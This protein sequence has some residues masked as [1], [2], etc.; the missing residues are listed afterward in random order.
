MQ[1]TIIPDPCFAGIPHIRSLRCSPAQ[2]CA[3][4]PMLKQGAHSIHDA[5][6]PARVP[7]SSNSS[8]TSQH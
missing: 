7:V 5:I 1:E 3:A 8:T 4:S 6:H 2:L